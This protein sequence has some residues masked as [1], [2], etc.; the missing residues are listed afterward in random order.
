MKTVAVFIFLLGGVVLFSR[1]SRDP[2]KED[3]ECV[4]NDPN[5]NKSSELAVLM[6]KMATHAEQV[7]GEVLA[8]KLKG[9]FP[10]EFRKILTAVPTDSLIKGDHFNEFAAGYL[11]NLELLYSGQADLD[12][13][14][15]AVANSCVSCHENTCPGPLV[16]IHKLKI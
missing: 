7:K 10:E 15:N 2:K 11:T 1:C 3:A 4:V 5:P 16:R 9:T 13:R 6:R 8:G 14:Y 12:A